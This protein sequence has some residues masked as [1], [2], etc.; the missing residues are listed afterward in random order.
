M[1]RSNPLRCTRCSEKLDESRAVWL[2]LDRDLL[3]YHL[4]GEV[5]PERSQGGFPFGEACARTILK[6]DGVCVKRPRRR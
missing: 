3:T 2:E 1:N 5:P 6:L 4:D